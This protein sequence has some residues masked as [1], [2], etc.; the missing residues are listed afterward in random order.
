MGKTYLM[1]KSSNAENQTDKTISSA[2]CPPQGTSVF[3]PLEEYHQHNIICNKRD[4]PQFW[5]VL[6]VCRAKSLLQLDHRGKPTD[7]LRGAFTR[8]MLLRT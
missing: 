2:S 5:Q 3:P 8:F 4:T 6:S 1:S 7:V